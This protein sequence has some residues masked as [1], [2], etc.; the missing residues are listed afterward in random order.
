VFTFIEGL[1]DLYSSPN[2][3]R[4]IKPRRM[5]RAVHVARLG[6]RRCA[7]S[8]LVEYPEEKRPHGIP[9]HIWEGNIK[10]DLQESG[11]AVIWLRIRTGAGRL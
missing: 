3:I 5:R 4:V 1:N 10:M 9:K 11:T 8:V 2:I 6:K 7:Y